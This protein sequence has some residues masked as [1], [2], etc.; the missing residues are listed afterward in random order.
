M[1]LIDIT[2]GAV[3]KIN[4]S[5][6]S[7]KNTDIE[8]IN[9]L[10]GNYA[11]STDVKKLVNYTSSFIVSSM[12]HVALNSTDPH[13]A[14]YYA[15]KY[16][17]FAKNIIFY[18]LDDLSK[19]KIIIDGPNG[20]YEW[21]QIGGGGGIG[22]Q[23]DP[24]FTANSGLFELKEDAFN[25]DYNNLT[26]KPTIPLS[27]SQLINDKGFLTDADFSDYALSADV[28]TKTSQLENDKGFLTE[29]DFN[30]Y[31]LS[32]DV[33]NL[34]DTTSTTLETKITEW[35]TDQH[36][37][38]EQEDPKFAT[39][40]G[41]FALKEDTTYISGEV[42]DLST[43]L[44][45]LIETTSGEVIDQIEQ[46]GYITG[47][48]LSSYATLTTLES[49]SGQL[50]GNIN[51]TN[52]KFVNYY[53]KEEISNISG[54]ITGWVEQQH[55]IQEQKDPVFASLSSKFALT[56]DITTLSTAIDQIND[57]LVKYAI[58]TEVNTLIDTVS[59]N[60]ENKIST[61]IKDM[62]TTGWVS[63]QGY[64]TSET[65]FESNSGLF[66]LTSEVANITGSVTG[67]VNEQGYLTEHQSLNNYA[68]LSTVSNISSILTSDIDT[69]STAIDNIS[70]FS[71]DY[72]DL[73][74]KPTIPTYTSQL[75]NDNEFLIGNKNNDPISNIT[76][77]TFINNPL[78]SG[79]NVLV[80]NPSGEA[81]IYDNST[82]SLIQLSHPVLQNIN[83]S[84]NPNEELATINV[85]T[86]YVN[87]SLTGYALSSDVDS[88]VT[89][90][91]DELSSIWD[92][93]LE[94]SGRI[95]N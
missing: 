82:S 61:A 16:H 76:S 29:A 23:K 86:G 38:S 64:I 46:K 69:L 20:T 42:D 25:G 70:G 13:D 68:Q 17:E 24:I 44:T 31:A 36:Y 6:S 7:L 35:V 32:T 67:W 62:A 11:L 94:L 21:R 56:G 58:S 5:I 19:T 34:I 65:E 66:V 55:Y 51:Q 40:S 79:N 41:S 26:N 3:N 89:H 27:T 85:I 52:D 43:N 91:L 72:N 22:T 4:Q 60:L 30:M 50:Q 80:F 53:D 71:G 12:Q 49:V 54:D 2:S 90:I 45:T 39:L 88:L 87:E 15:Q 95:G 18:E 74:N 63:E 47:V 73:I 93:V 78:L 75:I 1:A 92:A 57:Q 59:T 10:T 81:A 37:I 9:T 14:D 28:P 77:T 33:D 84:I 8:I 48:E 83:E